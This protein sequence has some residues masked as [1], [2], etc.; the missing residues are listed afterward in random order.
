MGESLTN[1]VRALLAENPKIRGGEVARLLDIPNPNA[2]ALLTYARRVPTPGGHGGRGGFGGQGGPVPDSSD[3]RW[4]A[5][6]VPVLAFLRGSPKG[7]SH[8]ELKAW[9]RTVKGMGPTRLANALGWL[10]IQGLARSDGER[11]PHRTA[12]KASDGASRA[13]LVRWFGGVAPSAEGRSRA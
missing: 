8:E 13:H 9:S 12:S 6:A 5:L 11:D 1:K 2:H 10:E 3:Q 4:P 7:R